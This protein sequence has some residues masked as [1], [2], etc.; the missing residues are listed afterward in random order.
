MAEPRLVL[1]DEPTAGVNP[2]LV[3]QI[4]SR[5]RELNARGLT[6]LVV[7]HNMNLVMRLCDPIVVLDHGTKL[8]DGH[9]DEV[10]NNPRVL[11]AYLGG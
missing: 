2:V 1:L 7:E 8:A 5:V 9:P 4:E 3:E 11:D 10:R 6:F